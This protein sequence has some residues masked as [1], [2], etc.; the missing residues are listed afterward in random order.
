MRLVANIRQIQGSY[1]TLS[2]DEK[3]RT[4]TFQFE[5]HRDPM[6]MYRRPAELLGP[7]QPFL[8]AGLSRP[9]NLPVPCTLQELGTARVEAI[10]RA[11]PA[12]PYYLGGWSAGATLTYEVA[13]Q[14]LAH[15][16]EVALLVLFDGTSPAFLREVSTPAGRT[17]HLGQKLWL[18]FSNLRT[19][20]V[21]DAP[22]YVAERWESLSKDLRM[23]VR[24]AWYRLR[25]AFGSKLESAKLDMEQLT[26]H[27]YHCYTLQPYP[28][29]VI[30]FSRESRR[31]GPYQDPQ[32]GRRGL[33]TGPF[34]ACEVPGNHTGIFLEPNVDIMRAK[35]REVM[36]EVQAAQE[37]YPIV[38]S[39]T[40]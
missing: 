16:E 37:P 31:E 32:F 26:F 19:G 34:E 36:L 20:D 10:R 17:R 7:D 1:G 21:K 9:E 35:L 38:V 13:Q 15:G 6:P 28:G 11:Q 22:A 30:L 25:L 24:L 3:R 27:C 39:P 23:K 18:H 29:R 5:K 8:C 2:D 40:E 12:G 14:L 33:V 4:D